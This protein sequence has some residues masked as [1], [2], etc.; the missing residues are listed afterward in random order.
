MALLRGINVSG[1]NKIPMAELRSLCAGM[2][3]RNVESYI[4]SGNLVFAADG[5]AAELEI[6]LEQA[7]K[8]RFDLSIPAIVRKAPDWPAYIL[9]NPF[10]EESKLEPNHVM[11]ILSKRLPKSDAAKT[12]QERAIAGERILGAGGALWI[13]F[14]ESVATSKLSPALLDRMIGSKATARNW[15]TVLKIHEMIN[16]ARQENER[17]LVATQEKAHSA[18]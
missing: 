11:L 17:S 4:Q 3:W 12:L 16:S 14:G 7:I 8:K 9:A 2:R 5:T 10:S 18:R 13:H 6:Q 15:N 1:H